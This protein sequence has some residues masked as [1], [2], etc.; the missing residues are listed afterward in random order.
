DD[1]LGNDLAHR[2]DLGGERQLPA[3]TLTRGE[4]DPIERLEA[5]AIASEDHGERV[6]ELLDGR[7]AVEID[8]LDLLAVAVLDAAIVH[9]DDRGRGALR[10][11]SELAVGEVDGP[12]I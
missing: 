6:D 2:R 10:S 3:P 5:L 12:G 4:L 11:A 1:H 9:D 7:L 8:A